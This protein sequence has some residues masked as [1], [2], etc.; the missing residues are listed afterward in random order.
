METAADEC[1]LTLKDDRE[2]LNVNLPR[3]VYQG[4][5]VHTLYDAGCGLIAA[6]FTV[7]GAVTSNTTAASVNCNLTSQA[8]GYFSL[9]TMTFTTGPNAGASR[10]IK[11]HPS[12]GVLVPAFPWRYTP[13]NGN[14]FT[15]KPGCDRLLATCNT[16]FSNTARIR[17]YPYI[18]TPEAA[19]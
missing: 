18:P 6:N 10:A 5:C 19:I 12:S 8:V 11:R 13:A 1:K 3:H 7:T 15:A 16:K 4:Q 9:G 17:I 2:L 14:Q